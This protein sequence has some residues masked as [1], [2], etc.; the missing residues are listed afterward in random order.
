M[1]GF[2]SDSQHYFPEALQGKKPKVG[3]STSC[4]PCEAR[5]KELERVQDREEFKRLQDVFKTTAAN[6]IRLASQISNANVARS[7]QGCVV[8][9]HGIK[10]DDE[11]Q[12]PS[13]ESVGES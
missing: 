11:T 1:V 12:S 10:T 6:L 9:V 4:A 13:H 2:G 8:G 3:S 5:I 7:G